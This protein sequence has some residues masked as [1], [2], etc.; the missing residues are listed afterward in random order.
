VGIGADAVDTK[1]HALT[2]ITDIGK[3]SDV[4]GSGKRKSGNRAERSPVRDPASQSQITSFSAA[5]SSIR[6]ADFATEAANLTKGAGSATVVGRGFG[7]ANAAPQS[8]LKLLQ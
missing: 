3:R 7:A 2:A 4:S 5:Q 8:L 1:A 6:Y